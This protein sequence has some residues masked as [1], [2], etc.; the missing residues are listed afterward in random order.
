MAAEGGVFLNNQA[1][2][3]HQKGHP[4]DEGNAQDFQPGCAKHH[5]IR[6]LQDAGMI[7]N[8]ANALADIHEGIGYHEAR[9][10]QI[11][12]DDADQKA[13]QHR[14]ENR[15]R[16]AEKTQIK[17]KHLVGNENARERSGHADH[18]V[19]GKVD[20]TNHNYIG[21]A[22][23]HA[24]RYRQ[25]LEDCGN[26]AGS[27]KHIEAAKHAEYEDHEYQDQHWRYAHDFIH[28]ICTLD[29][30]R[31]FLR[32][33]HVCASNICHSLSLHSLKVRSMSIHQ[34]NCIPFQNLLLWNFQ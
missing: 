8:A 4:G 19:N 13:D 33:R 21:Q 2:H 31:K 9:H 18:A 16:H 26:V 1:H 6:N 32:N 29:L 24:E 7:G 3:E 30:L 23:R 17:V 27:Q 22:Q 28:G 12:V 10:P 20:G 5:R 11:H 25:L 34:P 14:G 15:Q